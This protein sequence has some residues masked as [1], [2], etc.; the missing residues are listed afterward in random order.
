MLIIQMEMEDVLHVYI[1]LIKT[2]MPRYVIISFYNFFFFNMLA[3]APLPQVF[4][5]VLIS[6]PSVVVNAVPV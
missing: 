1:I 5:H 4:V 3:N 6:V 2:G